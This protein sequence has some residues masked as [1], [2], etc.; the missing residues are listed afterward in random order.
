MLQAAQGQLEWKVIRALPVLIAEA[1]AVDR[2]PYT[3]ESLGRLDQQGGAGHYE[4]SWDGL[5]EQG[6]LSPPG[7]YLLRVE[8]VGD[9]VTGSA[10]R[11]VG[12]AY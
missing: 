9:A 10:T 7:L 4:L 6:N 11:V 5:D 12:L 8:I 3:D 1:E 2:S